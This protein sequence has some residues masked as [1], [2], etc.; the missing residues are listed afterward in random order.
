MIRAATREDF[1]EIRDLLVRSNETPYDIARVA[2]E[3]VFGIGY[4][5]DPVVRVAECAGAIAGVAVTCGRALRLVAVDPKLRRRGIGS[6]LLT[7]ELRV[8]FAEAANYLTPGVIESDSGTRQFFANR[9]F[10]ESRWTWNLEATRLPDA[11]PADV[12]R[13]TLLDADRVLTFIAEEFGDIWRFEAGRAL[14]RQP[15]SLFHTELDGKVTGFAAHDV[16]NRGLGFFGPT[17]VA[18][19]QRGRGLGR[20]LLAASLADLRRLGYTRATIPW[21]DAPGFYQKAC[22]AEVVGRFVTLSR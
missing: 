17:G 12:H 15:A 21:T 20:S 2:E 3:K 10:V 18:R 13:T 7:P 9:G 6:S 22:G 8:I 5:G 16:N 11:V 14:T 19:P 4:H 1:D